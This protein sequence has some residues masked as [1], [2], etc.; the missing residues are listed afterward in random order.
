MLYNLQG[1]DGSRG[2]MYRMKIRDAPIKIFFISDHG[3]GNLITD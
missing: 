3:D 2:E 1:S